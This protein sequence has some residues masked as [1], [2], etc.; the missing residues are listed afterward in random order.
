M[1]PPTSLILGLAIV[2]FFD[3]A[4]ARI[5]VSFAVAGAEGAEGDAAAM[6]ERRSAFKAAA[7]VELEA[8]GFRHPILREKDTF[9]SSPLDSLN[10][11][12]KTHT[13]DF[14]SSSVVSKRRRRRRQAFPRSSRSR[15]STA[16][17]TIFSRSSYHSNAE[18]A[19]AMSSLNKQYPNMTHVYTIGES[20]R[21]ANL[22]VIAIAAKDAD[23]HV[24][25]RPEMK[26]VGNMHG[27]EVVGRELIIRY[28]FYLL[29][30]YVRGDETI[31]YLM[32][33][34]RI[35][36][37]PTMNPDGFSS[38]RIGNCG[39]VVGRQNA[40]GQDLNRNFPDY[41]DS[42][43]EPYRQPETQSIMDW[44]TE[45][46]F[47]LSAN[48]HGGA[49]VANYPFDNNED[50]TYRYS[51][52]PDDDIFVDLALT[53]A[54]SNRAMRESTE[55][56]RGITNGAS[57]YPLPGG[58]Q[59]WMYLRAG[60][61]ELTLEVSD[62]KYP[63]FSAIDG[64][65][66]DNRDSMTKFLL[67]GF[68][69]VKGVVRD[70]N[71]NPLPAVG[72]SVVGRP[73]VVMN[74]TKDGEFWRLLLPGKYQLSFDAP[75]CHTTVVDVTVNEDDDDGSLVVPLHEPLEV[76]LAYRESMRPK[77]PS[78]TTTTSATTPL[79]SSTTTT[80]RTDGVIG[81]YA[82]D[83]GDSPVIDDENRE[84]LTLT[85]PTTLSPVSVSGPRVEESSE[86]GRGGAGGTL[87]AATTR[88]RMQYFSLSLIAL[89][90]AR[91][92]QGFFASL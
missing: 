42:W 35:H 6:R 33:N 68:A 24:F 79:S 76:N 3:A 87:V 1:N 50:G 28:A 88:D 72:V 18:L 9:F 12:S 36:L 38:A 5:P 48:M 43:H 83:D 80:A 22:Y 85:P 77:Q 81:G 58:M 4:T 65:W 16:S 90:L 86:D 21:G 69:G 27:N 52:S 30:S 62:C 26:F 71:N 66:D 31:K 25:L 15:R 59:D 67:R 10:I 54:N 70:E 32:D 78:T 8:D 19:S 49:V 7:R 82:P 89:S 61:M 44:V 34:A 2:A 14:A 11:P 29:D 64:F 51:K 47:V 63:F 75:C 20:V 40:N 92:T 17:L 56:S 41:F 37:M 53:Y 13:S 74:T 57:W 23:K 60:C 91:M 84:A 46:Q 45:T 55:F 39:G 73:E